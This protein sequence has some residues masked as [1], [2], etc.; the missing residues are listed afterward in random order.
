QG[1]MHA[2]ER[3]WQMDFWRHIGAGRLS[4]MFGHNEVRTDSFI[5]TLGWPQV[6]DDQLSHMDP[7][8]QQALADYSAGINAY[9]EDHH[10]TQLSLEY[11]FLGLLTSLSQVNPGNPQHSIRGGLAMWWDR[12]K[13][14]SE[15]F[16]RASLLD[17]LTPEQIAQLSPPYPVGF[18]IIVSPG[19]D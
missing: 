8:S 15:E 7:E 12:S 11:V 14:L 16:A 5:R 13:T 6:A 18:P 4:E 17:Q 10:G 19:Q 1:Y 3:F 2:Q 9:L